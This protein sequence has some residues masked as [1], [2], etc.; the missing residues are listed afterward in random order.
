MPSK[1]DPVLTL[2]IALDSPSAGVSTS[3][4]SELDAAGFKVESVSP[5]GLLIVGE[6]SLIEQFFDTRID[7]SQKVPQFKGEPAFGRLP[8][9]VGYR[10]YFPKEPTYF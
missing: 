10:A 5:R 9:G 3:A 4:S 1:I 2:R 7:L 6:R 8:G